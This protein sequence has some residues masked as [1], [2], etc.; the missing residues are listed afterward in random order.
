MVERRGLLGGLMGAM[1]GSVARPAQALGGGRALAAEIPPGVPVLGFAEQR[2]EDPKLRRYREA[3]DVEWRRRRRLEARLS[4][5]GGVPPGILAC[6]SWKPW[7]QA[8]MVDRWRDE[9]LPDPSLVERLISE[10]V[11]GKERD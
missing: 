4:L 8:S 9:H 7:F 6:R 10:A 11:F 1:V 5:T 2:P 3:M